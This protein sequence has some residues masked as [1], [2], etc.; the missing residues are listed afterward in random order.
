M[1]S[2]PEAVF[3]FVAPPSMA[4]LVQ[5]ISGRGMDPA[6]AVGRRLD[7]AVPELRQ[8]RRF[9]YLIIND[10]LAQAAAKLE[11]ILTAERCR[12]FRLGPDPLAAI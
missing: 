11:A 8:A 3:V 6:D 2:Y 1:E 10:D 12:T 5:R 7:A 9:D 4:E